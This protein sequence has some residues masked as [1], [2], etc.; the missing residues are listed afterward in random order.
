M[1]DDDKQSDSDFMEDMEKLVYLEDLDLRLKGNRIDFVGKLV[2]LS[3]EKQDELK[4]RDYF[5]DEEEVK[6]KRKPN[7]FLAQQE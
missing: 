2:G 5:S 1:T 7:A 6:P 3:K 4:E